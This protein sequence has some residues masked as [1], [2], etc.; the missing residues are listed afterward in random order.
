MARSRSI[1][2]SLVIELGVECKA[3]VAMHIVYVL[4]YNASIFIDA[5]THTVL[6]PNLGNC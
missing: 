6:A 2:T 4:M 3:L 5:E 1:I